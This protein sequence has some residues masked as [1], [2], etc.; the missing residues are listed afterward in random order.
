LDFETAVFGHAQ[1]GQN[2]VGDCQTA[3]FHTRMWEAQLLAS[4][5][6]QGL[7]VAQEH[8][9]PAFEIQNRL[10]GKAT[11]E[12]VTANPSTPYDHVNAPPSAHPTERDEVF[13]GAAAV[14]FADTLRS[15]LQRSYHLLPHVADKPIIV[16]LADFHTPVSMVWSREALIGYL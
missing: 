13:F 6:E 12:A 15:K 14:R 10:G 1:S 5:R 8:L 2:W 3:N 11:V 4:F 16:T 7:L 9:S